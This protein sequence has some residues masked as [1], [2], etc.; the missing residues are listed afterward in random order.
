MHSCWNTTT[1]IDNGNTVIWID[2][3]FDMCSVTS[4]RFVYRVIYNFVYEVMQ[5]TSRRTTNI[6]PWAFTHRV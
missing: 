1:I 2:G 6:H 5:T 4:K 3:Y